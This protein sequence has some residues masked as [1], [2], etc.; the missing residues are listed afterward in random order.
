MRRRFVPELL[1]SSFF[2]SGMA[3]QVSRVVSLPLLA[4]AAIGG[5]IAPRSPGRWLLCSLLAGYAGFAA[6]F[7][8]HM[9][10]H[11]YYH[12]P[13]IAVVSLGVAALAARVE[14]EA[15]ARVSRWTLAGVSLA[16]CTAIGIAGALRALPRMGTANA[17]ALVRSYEEIGELTEHDTKVVFLDAEYG[18][19]LMYHG[20]LSGDAWPNG[21]DLAAEEVTG[22]AALTAEARFLRD[23]ADFAPR[24]FVVT[25]LAALAASPDLQD[26]LA[27]RARV[28]RQTDR[29]HVYRFESV[30]DGT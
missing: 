17:A 14:L 15:A 4:G 24:F 13:Y 20:Q 11:D 28:V 10:T 8:Y 22:E 29:Y 5:L 16:L 1:W 7:T 19:P 18:Y 6:A 21:D 9:P 3:I 2:W 25:D 12:L 26:M 27:R 30:A 23:Y